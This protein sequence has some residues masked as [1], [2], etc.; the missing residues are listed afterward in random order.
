MKATETGVALLLVLAAV[1]LLSV[2]T[3]SFYRFSV[4]LHLVETADRDTEMAQDLV[5]AAEAPIEQWLRKRSDAVVLPP[6]APTPRVV[7][8]QERWRLVGRPFVLEIVAYDQEGMVSLEAAKGGSPLWAVL[9]EEVRRAIERARWSEGATLGLDLFAVGAGLDSG[10]SP[11][12]VADS[13]GDR[14][15]QAPLGALVATHNDAPGSLNVHTAPFAMLDAVFRGQGR[16]GLELILDARLQGVPVDAVPPRAETS[17]EDAFPRLTLQ[18]TTWA[19]RTDVG[20]GAVRIS[21]WSI[22]RFQGDA[23]WARVQRLQIT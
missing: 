3:L 17:K 4:S 23:G 1:M 16:G 8:L 22:F 9:S 10:L 15:S 20:V 19:F 14:S 21:Y 11:Y 18:S 7:V 2:T 6:D 5:D 13:P 12:P